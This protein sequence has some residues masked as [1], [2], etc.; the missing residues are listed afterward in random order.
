MTARCEKTE[1]PVDGCVHCRGHDRPAPERRGWGTLYGPATAARY[2]SDCAT[3]GGHYPA[4]TPI[5]RSPDGWTADCC[6]EET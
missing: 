1:L 6:P 5:H 3:C 2:P 4:G